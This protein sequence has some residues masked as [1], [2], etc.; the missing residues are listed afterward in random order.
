M[1]PQGAGHGFDEVDQGFMAY[2]EINYRGHMPGFWW[3]GGGLG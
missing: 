1:V 3:G 2:P